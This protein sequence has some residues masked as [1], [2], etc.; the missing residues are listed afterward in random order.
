RF[1]FNLNLIDY[2][3]DEIILEARHKDEV[4]KVYLDFVMLKSLDVEITKL[5]YPE[6]LGYNKEGNLT[7]YLYSDKE[8]KNIFIEVYPLKKFTIENF[9][10][11]KAFILP[12]KGKDLDL[13]GNIIIDISY[14]DKNIKQN[15]KIEVINIPWYGKIKMLFRG[16]FRR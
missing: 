5:E 12:F 15:F 2:N 9:K 1:N 8:I 7:F 14:N 4:K 13:S 6:I 10:D 16:L 11:Y 3:K